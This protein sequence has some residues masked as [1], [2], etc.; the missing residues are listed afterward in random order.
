MGFDR[1]DIRPTMDVFTSDNVYLGTVL[2]IT[3]G[4]AQPV[5]ER[6]PPSARQSSVIN[7]ELLGPAPT[8]PL[9]NPGPLRQAAAAGYAT[10]ADTMQLLGKGTISVGRWWGLFGKR[11]IPLA[12]V[13]TVSLERV[14][15]KWR[16]NELDEAR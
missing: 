1:R 10:Q 2:G 5:G 8:Q 11:H 12:A 15:L 6:V 9:G 13:Q 14:V 16:Y 3:V 4:V 7:G